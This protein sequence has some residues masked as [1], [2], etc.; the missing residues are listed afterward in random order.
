MPIL[1]ILALVPLVGSFV[2]AF[3]PGSPARSKT[4]AL[5]FALATF[6]LTIV[7]ITQYDTASPDQFQLVDVYSW[8][9][10]LGLNFSLGVDGLGL[11]M[12]FLATLLTP[13]VI[14]AGWND[15]EDSAEQNPVSQPTGQVRGY[16]ALMLLMLAMTVTVFT[17][18]DV[19]LFYFVFEAV[20]IPVYFMIGRYG[21][22]RRAYA[23]VKFLVYSLVGALVMLAALA[24]LWYVSVQAFD[25]PT[26]YLPDLMT[27]DIDPTLQNWLFLGFFLAFAIKAPL[28]PVHTW[29]P[30]AAG[31]STPGTAILLIGVLDKLGTFGMLRFC[32]PLFP[33]AAQT[34]APVIMALAVIS[35]FYGGLVAIGQTDMKRLFGYVSISH[36][37]FIVLGIFAFTTQAQ[38]GSAFYML[39]HGIS[40]A[41]LF[42]VAGYLITRRGTSTIG[43]YSGVSSVTPVLAG[44]FLFAGLTAL[45]LPGLS[46]FLSEF[47]VLL[48]TFSRYPW[49][50][51]FATLGIVLAA[52]YILL[53]YQR[54]MTGPTSET[55]KGMLDLNTREK[56]ALAPL[57][58]VVIFLGFYP[59][60][61]LDVLNP[62]VDDVM[63]QVG[64][65][66]PPPTI[67]LATEGVQP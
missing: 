13:L 23:A 30:D 63:A 36:F 10:S 22:G 7:A 67:P 62:F 25:A 57:V 31:S 54:T 38:V 5:L 24:V 41:L 17:A 43:A 4:I 1:T 27:I 59:A 66:D 53:L 61:A 64:Q 29:L 46:T 16:F 6:A 11:I 26:L 8:I 28:F 55:A 39:G 56:V 15:V 32:L 3:V 44:M 60:P 14:L 35:I 20:L 19:F 37:G 65:T 33:D 2:V 42:M 47:L 9:P 21:T 51:A 45:A 49:L 48:G 52:V 12:V 34:F 40:T 18:L 50:A 58:A